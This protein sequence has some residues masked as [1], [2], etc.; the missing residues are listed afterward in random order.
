MKV[1]EREKRVS[2]V[3]VSEI[4]GSYPTLNQSFVFPFLPF[5]KD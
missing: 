3:P 2:K 1:R 4:A 5:G